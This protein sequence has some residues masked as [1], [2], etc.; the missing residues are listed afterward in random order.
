MS[1]Q[2]RGDRANVILEELYDDR[3]LNEAYVILSEPGVKQ[4]EVDEAMDQLVCG[5]GPLR[6]DFSDPEF[7]QFVAF[8]M[9]H[10]LK[11]L[12]HQDPFTHRSFCKPRGYAGD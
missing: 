6:E 9:H 5:L 1:T 11:E 10:P 7:G 2:D 4:N 12:I 8:C 3:L